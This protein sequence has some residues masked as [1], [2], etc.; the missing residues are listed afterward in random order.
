MSPFNQPCNPPCHYGNPDCATCQEVIE[1]GHKIIA[2]ARR[3]NNPQPLLIKIASYT[4]FFI[5]IGNFTVLLNSLTASFC[6]A[7]GATMVMIA[8]CEH[9]KWM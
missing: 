6:I 2:K 4:M 8:L 3:A 1:L 9:Y 7:A 5:G